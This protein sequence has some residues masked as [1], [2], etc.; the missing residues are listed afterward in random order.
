MTTYSATYGKEGLAELIS[1]LQ[2]DCLQQ[3]CKAIVINLFNNKSD[4]HVMKSARRQ[5]G[6][7][8]L[9]VSDNKFI[10]RYSS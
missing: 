1:R 8:I 2:L 6:L 9:N 4:Y 5:L 7:D 10:I 3:T